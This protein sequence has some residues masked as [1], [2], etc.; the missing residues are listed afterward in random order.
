MQILRVVEEED[1]AAVEG[2]VEGEGLLLVRQGEQMTWTSLGIL[3][4]PI[5]VEVISRRKKGV[6]IR[7]GHAFGFHVKPVMWNSLM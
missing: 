7:W 6:N 5:P 4:K 3:P 2:V 1:R